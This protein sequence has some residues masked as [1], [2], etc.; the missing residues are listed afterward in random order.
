MTAHRTKRG[1]GCGKGF[2][3]LTGLGVHNCFSCLIKCNAKRMEGRKVKI[4]Q[5]D[6]FGFKTESIAKQSTISRDVILS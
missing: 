1:S 2:T 6:S 5:N 4:Q 3:V